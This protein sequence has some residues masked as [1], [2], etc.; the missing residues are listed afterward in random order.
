MAFGRCNAPA[1]FERLMDTLL[2]DLRCL[3]YLDDIIFHAMTFDL[4][5]RRLRPVFFRLWTANLKLSPKKCELFR[6][7]V[8]S[9]GRVVC[10]DG[11]TTDPDKV[12]AVQN[13]PVPHNAMAVVRFIGLCNY[14]RRC[15]F[16]LRCG[17]SSVSTVWER[18]PLWVDKEMQWFASATQ[19]CSCVCHRPCVPP[20]R[21][22]VSTRLNVVDTKSIICQ[23]KI[24]YVPYVTQIR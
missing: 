20:Q 12:K 16:L 11:V 21:R 5:L 8:K 13:V 3:I 6:R 15:V 14:Y 4:E 19:S 10:E 17:P 9:R 22:T 18:P 2:G 7:K 24:D 23:E 1:T